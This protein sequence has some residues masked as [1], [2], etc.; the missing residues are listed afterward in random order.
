MND[1]QNKFETWL[2]RLGYAESSVR[3]R[4]RQ[5]AYFLDWLGSMEVE[6]VRQETVEAY[7]AHLHEKTG[8]RSGRGLSSRTIE[9]C[10]SVLRLLD[11]YRIKHG[12][13]PLLRALPKVEHGGRVVRKMVSQEQVTKLYATVPDGVRG[14]YLRCLRQCSRRRRG[15]SVS[16]SHRRKSFH[17]CRHCRRRRSRHI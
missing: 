15:R 4:G 6:E 14:P 13:M 2:R 17:L 5:L 8:K 11:E 7:A 12:K 3:S 9:A 16:H 1:L 10:L